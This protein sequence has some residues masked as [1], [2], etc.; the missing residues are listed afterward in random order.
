M[1]DKLISLD[2]IENENAK[3]LRS[4]R[5][6]GRGQ[7]EIQENG[8]VDELDTQPTQLHQNSG[9]AKSKTVRSS[10]RANNNSK[11]RKLLK[12]SPNCKSN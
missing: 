10:S 6:G 4:H 8:G 5:E 11:L 3:H 9:R 7:M 1:S 2:Q 12:P